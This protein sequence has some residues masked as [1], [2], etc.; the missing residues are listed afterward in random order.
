[1]TCYH[2][3][4]L[5]ADHC[6]RCDQQREVMDI[7]QA[8]EYL[9]ISTDTLYRYASTRF[10]PSFQLGNRWRFKK[11]LLDEWMTKKSRSSRKP[12]AVH[13]ANTEEG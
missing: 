7:N 13:E 1:M 9:G 8:A 11:S 5:G 4:P 6:P 2:T 10:I 3:L 12:T